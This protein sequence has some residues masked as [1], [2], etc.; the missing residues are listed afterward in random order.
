MLSDRIYANNT[1]IK[2]AFWYSNCQKKYN[3]KLL[4]KMLF[5]SAEVDNFYMH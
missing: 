4:L 2:D 3:K 5:L 1:F